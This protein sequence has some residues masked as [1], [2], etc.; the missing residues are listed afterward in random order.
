M[1]GWTVALRL[2][3]VF[4]DGMTGS[5][6]APCIGGTYE[7]RTALSLRFHRPARWAGS[8]ENELL[9]GLDERFA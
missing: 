3:V 1:E 8:A 4:D 7:H 9:S 6:N 5:S 2:V